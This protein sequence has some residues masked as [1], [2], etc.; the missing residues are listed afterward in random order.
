MAVQTEWRGTMDRVGLDKAGVK[1]I[2]DQR[3]DWRKRAARC[4]QASS[5]W[6]ARRSM[7]GHHSL[8]CRKGSAR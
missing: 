7:R 3:R 6:S 5:S 4:S 1:I 8:K 2:I